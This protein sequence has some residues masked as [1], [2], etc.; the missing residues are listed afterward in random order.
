MSE[1]G[2]VPRLFSELPGLLEP[3]PN[4]ADLTEYLDDLATLAMVTAMLARRAAGGPQGNR[5]RKGGMDPARQVR[6]RQKRSLKR[7]RAFPPAGSVGGPGRRT[8]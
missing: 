2:A 6:T 7:R 1:L 8:A 4:A 5:E 3:L